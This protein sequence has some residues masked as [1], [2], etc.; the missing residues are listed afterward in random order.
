MKKIP[1]YFPGSVPRL[2]R[3]KNYPVHNILDPGPPCKI[4]RAILT[5][6]TF[7][8]LHIDLLELVSFEQYIVKAPEPMY[9]AKKA[10]PA[11]HAYLG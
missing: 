5:M 2:D 9:K 11:Q 6:Y 1:K 4:L 7:L 3:Y 8:T 10:A